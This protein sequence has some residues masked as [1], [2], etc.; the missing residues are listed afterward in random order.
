MKMKKFISILL[1]IL[2]VSSVFVGVSI[3]AEDSSENKD[4]KPNEDR[5]TIEV[6]V[7]ETTNDKGE[8]SNVTYKGGIY[9]GPYKGR[10]LRYYFAMPSEWKT[11][12]NAKACAYWWE[13]TDKC[14]N[15]QHSYQ[16]KSTSIERQDGTKVYYIDVSDDVSNI[17]FSNGIDVGTGTGEDTSPNWGKS[18]QTNNISLEGYTRD[19]SSVFPDGIENFNNLVYVVNTNDTSINQENGSVVFNGE[20]YYLHTDGSWDDKAGSQYQLE[21]VVVKLNKNQV[22]LNLTD[23]KSYTL[24]TSIKNKRFDTKTKWL[25]SDEKVVKVNDNGVITAVGYGQAIVSISVH[26]PG[27]S[28]I[29]SAKCIVNV[30]KPSAKKTTVNLS[31]PSVR[32]YVKGTTTIK[33]VIK[34]GVGKTTFKSSN[35]KVAKVDNNGKVTALKVGKVKVVVTNNKVSKIFNVTVEN[36]KLNKTKVTLNVKKPYTLKVV[37]KVGKVTFTSSN[38]KVATVDSLGKIIPKKKGNTTITVKCNGITMK[39]SVVVK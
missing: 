9:D 20:W 7:G 16:M 21:N 29:K 28:F 26:N 22:K 15:W 2:V 36:P 34:N 32:L 1:S 37:G 13:G 6:A 3:S 8:T 11:F 19:E 4:K 33:P 12:T 23:N 17:I 35:V 10:K 30:V 25:S 5:N 18:Y 38:T 31:K 27:D 14:T 39:C 24:K